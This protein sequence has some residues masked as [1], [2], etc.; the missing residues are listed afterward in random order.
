MIHL[1]PIYMELYDGTFNANAVIVLLIV[2]TTEVRC[3]MVPRCLITSTAGLPAKLPVQLTQ[4]PCLCCKLGV[5]L[6]SG[7]MIISMQSASM[8]SAAIQHSRL[9]GAIFGKIDR[10]MPALYRSKSL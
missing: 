1:E 3:C 8:L 9:L 7:S 4:P 5:L 2:Q 10:L 6:V